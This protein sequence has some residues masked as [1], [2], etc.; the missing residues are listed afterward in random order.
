[1]KVINPEGD[2][3]F[4]KVWEQ[5]TPVIL[6]LFEQHRTSPPK[7]FFIFNEPSVRIDKADVDGVVVQWTTFK[8]P[9]GITP[10]L[11]FSVTGHHFNHQKQWKKIEALMDA[12]ERQLPE[13]EFTEKRIW[14][15]TADRSQELTK[16]NAVESPIVESDSTQ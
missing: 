14:L 9:D 10:G 8:T 6:G 5:T 16:T 12:F 4:Q 3:S 11:A 1:M 13:I 15:H 2:K 7:E